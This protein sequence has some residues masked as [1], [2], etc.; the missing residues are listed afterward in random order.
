MKEQNMQ[1]ELKKFLMTEEK[2]KEIYGSGSEIKK[3]MLQ[4]ASPEKY[5]S[6]G[7]GIVNDLT[8]NQNT[9]AHKEKVQNL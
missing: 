1:K 8:G 6:E 2:L 4:E 7:K 9:I 3:L 5:Q